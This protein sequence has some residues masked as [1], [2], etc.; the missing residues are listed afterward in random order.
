MRCSSPSAKE[1]IQHSRAVVM[2]Y[3]QLG[4]IRDVIYVRYHAQTNVYASSFWRIWHTK[5]CGWNLRRSQ[6]AVKRALSSIGMIRFSAHLSLHRISNSYMINLSSLRLHLNRSSMSW[7]RL[8]WSW[9]SNQRNSARLILWRTLLR[10]GWSCRLVASC[11]RSM[12]S[13][14]TSRLYQQE[15]DTRNFIPATTRSGRSKLS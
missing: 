15:L 1:I 5:K 6:S 2:Q 10:G 14:K 4:L 9:S 3:R 11:P 13:L 12:Q 7:I 8:Q